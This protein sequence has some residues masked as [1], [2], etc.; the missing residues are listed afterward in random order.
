M[1]WSMLAISLDITYYRQTWKHTLSSFGIITEVQRKDNV[2][3][4]M[5]LKALL[6]IRRKGAGAKVIKFGRM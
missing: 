4:I 3:L 1:M 2:L 6:K 5:F